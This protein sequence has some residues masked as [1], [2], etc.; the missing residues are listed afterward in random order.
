MNRRALLIGL[1]LLV[2]LIAVTAIVFVRSQQSFKG[3]VITPPWPAADFTLTDHHGQPFSIS[4][5]RGKVVLLYFGYTNCPVEC[6]LTMAHFKL[7]LE[8]LGDRSKNVQV[9]MVSTSPERLLK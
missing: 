8:E 5:Q 7:A 6:P 9:L 3:S 1:T 2:A 4:S